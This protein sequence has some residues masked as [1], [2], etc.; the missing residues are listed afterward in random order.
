MTHEQAVKEL[1]K[2]KGAISAVYTFTVE[3]KKEAIDLAIKAL[4]KAKG[5]W[6]DV[7]VERDIVY[8]TGIRYTCSECGQGN[9]YG[10]PPYCMYCGAE[11][12]GQP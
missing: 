1:E 12:E 7:P 6:I 8:S 5:H 11:M 9:C 4:S 3:E 10:H 2:I